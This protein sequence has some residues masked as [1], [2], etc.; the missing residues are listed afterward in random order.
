MSK[1]YDIIVIGGGP[2]G[3]T[4]G[5]NA[6]YRG[7]KTLV[8]EGDSKPGGQPMQLYPKKIILDHPGFPHG[9][10]GKALSMRLYEQTRQSGAEIHLNEPA[11]ELNLRRE[12]KLVKT[13]KCKY[14]GKRIILATGLHNIPRKLESLADYK[15]KHVH[16]F[17]KHPAKFSNKNVI[18]VGGGDTAFERAHLLCRF[19]KSVTVLIREGVPKA[20]ADLVALSQK[21]GAKVMYNTEL[22]GFDDKMAYLIKK[23]GDKRNKVALKAEDV[24]ISIGFVTTLGILEKAGVEKDAKGMVK[25]NSN[26][27][28][29]IPGVFAAGDL[30]G[31]VKLISLSCAEGILAAINTFNSIKRPYW[32]HDKREKSPQS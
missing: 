17:I 27:E 4:A 25:V 23:D 2:A 8:L 32:L 5:A 20:K 12:P 9:I 29:S 22:V 14:Y 24:V 19:A 10:S 13:P 18:V 30:V 1:I 3:L 6:A 7:L 15:G 26:M 21:A 16:Y 31:E 28:T 11:I